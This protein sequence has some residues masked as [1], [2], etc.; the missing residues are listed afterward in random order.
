MSHRDQSYPE[1]TE[2]RKASR[3]QVALAVMVGQENG[4]TRDVSGTGIY[5]NLFDRS[6]Q[7]PTP[8]SRVGLT[9]S[10]GHADPKGPVKVHCAGEVLRVEP[11]EDALGLAVRL[12]SYHFE[13]V[14]STDITL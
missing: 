5:I 7:D 6:P 11:N 4:W 9:L 3:R 12:E 2:R 13:I 14:D 10:L 1:G 8:G